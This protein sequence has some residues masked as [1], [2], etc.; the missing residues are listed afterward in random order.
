M[1][2]IDR[3]VLRSHLEP[4][5]I[6]LSLATGVLFLNVFKEY[7][8]EFLAKGISPFTITEVLFLSLG[9]T[10]ALSI[11]MAV[12]FAT[13]MAFGQMAADNEVTALKAAGVHLYRVMLPAFIGAAIVCIVMM[14]FN[15][16]VL[17]ESNHRLAALTSDIG[18]KRPTVNIEPGRFVSEFKGYQLLI[19]DK[20][21]KSDAV[22]DVQVYVEHAG[23]PPDLLVAPRGRL[24]FVNG[25]STLYIELFDGEMH[26]VPESHRSGEETVY[27]VTRFVDHTVVIRDVGT[28]LQRTDRKY[29]GDREM[30]VGMLEEAMAEKRR[31]MNEIEDRLG[32]SA[33]QLVQTKLSLL[34][35]AQRAAYFER[36]RPL[37][38]GRLTMGSEQRLRDTVHMEKSS[39]E[40]FDRQIQAYEVEV[41]KKYAIPIASLVFVLLGAPLAIRSGRSGATMAI[42]FSMACFTIYYLFLTGGEKLADRQRISPFLAMWSANIFFGGLG[43]VMAWRASVDTTAWN[44]GR[45]DPRNWMRRRRR[46]NPR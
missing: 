30:S 44:W 29:R 22:R 42:G 45:F 27:R 7:L 39:I 36:H 10:L 5:I 16:Y 46:S 3:H 28:N 41:H 11:P 19:G 17:P 43:L 26:S 20:D 14:L 23:R 35:P 34:D 38:V 2:L 6:G 8:D 24:Y 31:M 33:M 40:A 32:D 18:R 9:H 12:L 13:L 4:F 21:E 15:N 37:P 25:G 1:K